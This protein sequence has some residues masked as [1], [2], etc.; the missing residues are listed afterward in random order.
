MISQD[1]IDAFN[2]ETLP[3]PIREDV[4]RALRGLDSAMHYLEETCHYESQELDDIADEL[5]SVR[6]RMEGLLNGN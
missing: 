6:V 2:E 3:H 4:V 1:D 5:M